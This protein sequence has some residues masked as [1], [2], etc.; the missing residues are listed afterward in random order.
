MSARTTARRACAALAV[1]SAGLHA[2]MVGHAGSAVATGLMALMIAA[3]LY[4]GLELWHGGSDR[5]WVV[6]ALM[7]LAMVAVHLPAP[8][9]HHGVAV[10]DVAPPSSVMA[11]ATVLALVE[12]TAAAAVLTVRARGRAAELSGTPGRTAAGPAQRGPQARARSH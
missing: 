5:A 10:G 2:A 4:C 8:A 3:C 11:V 12:A 6:V 7:N 1:G 9:H